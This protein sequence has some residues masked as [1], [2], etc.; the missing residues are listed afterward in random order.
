M[1][2]APHLTNKDR[3]WF[4]LLTRPILIRYVAGIASTSIAG[5]AVSGYDRTPESQ[6]AIK[7][8]FAPHYNSGGTLLG[9]AALVDCSNG[10]ILW[11]NRGTVDNILTDLFIAINHNK[12]IESKEIL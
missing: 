10:E 4:A 9:K 2:D 3:S 5:S 1:Q 12:T 6:N 8:I 11:V 7:Q